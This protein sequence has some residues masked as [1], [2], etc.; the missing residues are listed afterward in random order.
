MHELE[1]HIESTIE[2]RGLLR[3]SSPVLVA[4]SGGADSV[5]LLSVL[6]SLGYDCIAAHCNFHLRGA[7]S[8][9]DMRHAEKIARQL[10]TNI[11]IKEFD[12]AEQMKKSGESVEM[13]CRTLRYEWF[14]ELL[15]R[16]FSQAVAVAHHR[17][18]NV[19]TFFLNLMR[20]TGI[21]GLTGMD[22][23]RGFIVRPMLDISR[24]AIENYLNDKG[25]EYVTDSSNAENEYRRNCLRN[26]IIP[27]LEQY[28]P[29]ATNAILSTMEHLRDSRNLIDFALND[30]LGESRLRNTIDVK[31]L[32]ERADERTVR[33]LLFEHLKNEGFT[34]SQVSNIVRA[35][36]T[37]SS[38]LRFETDKDRVAEL[39]RGILSI[40]DTTGQ[41][42]S[43]ARH[44]VSLR[45]DI[46]TPIHIEVTPHHVTEFK[47]EH[48]AN[49]MYLD[50]IAN[51][52]E[53]VFELRHPQT[54]DRIRPF[55]MRGEKLVSDVLKDAKF[56]AAQKRGCWLLT[57]NDEILW[58][59]GLRA[60]H[61]YSITPK[62]RNYLRLEFK[63]GDYRR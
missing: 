26:I 35:V 37:G 13:A 54:G 7:E 18:D 60:S 24:G 11:Y 32:M 52:E 31:C 17:E 40:N 29:N 10:G 59:V 4:L 53:S 45:H 22:Y 55:G 56:S 15:D 5:A 61:K 49:V 33:G 28:F 46:L 25:L 19:E 63:N 23:R 14:H 36:K 57:R 48:N 51:D 34:A 44:K 50:A 39:D 6:T 3:R 8:I 9:R 2:E 21:D 16:D 62:T 20:S 47:P 42:K 38:G 58:I 43:M 12:V 41:K 30:T 27:A 1:R